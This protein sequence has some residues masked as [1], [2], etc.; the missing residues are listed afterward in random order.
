ML[1]ILNHISD[2][3][4]HL[5]GKCIKKIQRSVCGGCSA[6]SYHVIHDVFVLFTFAQ[7]IVGSDLV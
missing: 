1:N 6:L 2:R 3:L 7:A 4:S 5:A